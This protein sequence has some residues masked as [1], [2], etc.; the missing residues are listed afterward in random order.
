MLLS[1]VNRSSN[2]RPVTLD[3]LR[4]ASALTAPLR[5]TVLTSR[6]GVEWSVQAGAGPV[7]AGFAAL[8]SAPQPAT[9]PGEVH[10]D[11]MGAGTIPDVFDGDNEAAF[12]WIGRTDWT[13][14]ARFAWE[15]GDGARHELVAE[16]LDTIATVSLN[17]TELGRTANQHRSHRF[18]VTDVL[19]TGENELVIEFA[20]PVDAAERMSQELGPRPHVNRHPFN[21]IRKMAS[22]YGWDWGP[23]VAT[24]GI[25]RPIRIES[26]SDVRIASVRP[27]ATLDGDRGVLDAHVDLA[28]TDAPGIAAATVTVQVGGCTVAAIV[29]AGCTSVLVTAVVDD[30]DRWW[31]RG[32][33]AQPLYPVTVE[34]TGSDGIAHAWDGRVGFR[35]VTLDVAPDEH[36]E[37]FTISVNGEPVYVRGAN[38]IP[39]DAFVTRLDGG[40]HA[41]SVRDAVDAGMNLLRV[42]GGGLYESEHFYR[43]CDELGVLVWQDFLFACAAYAEE[44]PL[45]G[46]VEAEAR[47]AVTR[48]VGADR[49][50]GLRAANDLAGQLI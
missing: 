6:A 4:S 44:E 39:D 32:H 15:P 43:A 40:T 30:V 41:R 49:C 45:R 2:F 24:V 42:W 48:T 38:W 28:W 46:E 18:D 8:R 9:V 3:D 37:P 50:A 16:G 14:R 35:T 13:Y 27:L 12:A 31:P 29:P 22:N 34:V 23:D 25:W 21:G 17:G 20:A 47:E 7:P 33:G 1:E 36:G 19:V 5:E 10:T 11:L 26:W